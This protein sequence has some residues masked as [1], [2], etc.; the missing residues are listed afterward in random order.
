VQV[1]KGTLR[2]GTGA[3]QLRQGLVV[4]QF[5]LSMMM[6]VATL[7]VY[8]Q[9]QFIRSGDIGLQRENL[10]HFRGAP[11]ITDHFEAYRAELLKQPGVQQVTRASH[12]PIRVGLTSVSVEWAGKQP[13][14]IISFQIL[15]TDYDLLSISGIRLK[16]GRDFSRSFP[17]DSAAY[18]VNEKA[19]RLMGMRNPLGQQLT[20]FDRKGTIIGLVKDFHSRDIH[21]GDGHS[22]VP[23]LVMALRPS[24]CGRVLVRTQA[25]KTA[26]AIASLEK[27][28]RKYAREEWFEYK[29]TDEDFERMYRGDVM[30][31]KLANGFA[32]IAIFI[33]CLGLF[34]L[35]AFTAEKRTKEIG[36]RKVLGANVAGIVALLSREFLKPVLLA[37][38]IASPLA[39]YIMDQWLGNFTQRTT[40]GW[41]VFALAGGSAL[42]VALLT[43]SFQSIKA[44]LANPVK[45]L[46]SE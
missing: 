30:V 34:G 11:A 39:W 9:I 21:V 36:I 24:D 4:F 28:H 23:P 5:V 27:L 25:G 6:I 42:G 2:I 40:I 41:P 37:I 7:V 13:G 20:V 14:E 35:A 8:R 16:D 17:T 22:G 46:R 15:K 31:G 38:L 29:F 10:I 43:V 44:A 45:S 19:A 12:N 1:L 18:L 33:S 32:F 26:E 3:V